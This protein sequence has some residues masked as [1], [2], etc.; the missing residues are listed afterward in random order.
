MSE[1]CVRLRGLP[2]SATKQEIV[3]FLTRCRVAGGPDGVTIC[4]D[5]R[6]GDWGFS[7][8]SVFFFIFVQI[9]PRKKCKIR[10]QKR[11]ESF[12]DPHL[13]VYSD[14]GPFFSPSEL[15]GGGVYIL[16]YFKKS[17]EKKIFS[18]CQ[19]KK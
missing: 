19:C 12:S 3:D 9:K 17:L 7:E 5:D 15:G 18:L 8:F 14:P 6:S 4:K 16:A 10:L 13:L 1:Y 11:I 2:W